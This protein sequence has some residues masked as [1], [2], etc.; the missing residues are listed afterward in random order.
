MV[1]TH[2]E[3]R[4]EPVSDRSGR[5][6]LTAIRRLG[7]GI[8]LGAGVG[9]LVLPVLGSYSFAETYGYHGDFVA[10][11]GLVVG[12]VGESLPP[13][14]GD[15]PGMGENRRQVISTVTQTS[16]RRRIDGRLHQ[17]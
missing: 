1:G 10:M 15:G 11:H 8:L 9:V 2:E 17:P 16:H 14:C 3:K 5:A 13:V 4:S 6:R 12:A 7:A